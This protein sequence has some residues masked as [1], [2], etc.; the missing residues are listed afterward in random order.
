MPAV[1]HVSTEGRILPRLP[2]PSLTYADP[3]ATRDSVMSQMGLPGH[4]ARSLL[5]PL[6]VLPGQWTAPFRGGKC[7]PAR[8]LSSRNSFAQPGAG[9]RR[10]EPPLLPFRLRSTP[11]GNVPGDTP[12]TL[13][14]RW[15]RRERKEGGRRRWGGGGRG[16][17]Q[18]TNS[19]NLV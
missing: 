15:R 1:M 10:T 2:L 18:R 6:Q 3:A 12:V 7:Q 5:L 4:S 8:G 19:I 16:A 9:A 11:R 13:A 17:T 14:E